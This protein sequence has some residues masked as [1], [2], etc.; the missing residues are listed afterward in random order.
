MRAAGGEEER[1]EVYRTVRDEIRAC[2]NR[3][4]ITKDRP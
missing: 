1:L 3:E 4:L 2:K